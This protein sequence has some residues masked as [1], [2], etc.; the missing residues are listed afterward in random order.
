MVV[1]ALDIGKKRIGAALWSPASRIVTP[2]ALIQVKKPILALRDIENLADEH[3]PSTIVLG[4]P[5]MPNGKPGELASLVNVW[6]N[7]LHERFEMPIELWDE[8]MTSKLAEQDLRALGIAQKEQR[9]LVDMAAA[10]RILESW[11]HAKGY[12][13]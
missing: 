9:S 10:M 6:V 2:L 12:L 11:L 1:L 4:Y 7:K 8:R 5:L 3:N 13:E